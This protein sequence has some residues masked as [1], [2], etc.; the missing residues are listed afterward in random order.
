MDKA[1]TGVTPF[2]TDDA[3]HAAAI[4]EEIESIRANLDGLVAELDYRRHRLSPSRLARR[5]PSFF[6]L[7]GMALLAGVVGASLLAYRIRRRNLH[8]WSRRGRRLADAVQRLMAGKSIEAPPNVAR[9][10]LAAAASAAATIAG[11]RL[12]TRF[13]KSA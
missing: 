10:A 5:H 8:S 12:A 13:V 6:A 2:S 7:L 9:K 1:A 11:R 3:K 4:E